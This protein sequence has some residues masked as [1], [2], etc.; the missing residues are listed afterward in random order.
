MSLIPRESYSF[1]EH[2]TTTVV[3]SR[4]PKAQAEPVPVESPRKNP[5]IVP[6]PDPKPQPTASPPN[7]ALRRANAPPPRIPETPPS[8]R[9]PLSPSLKPKG[10]W[11]QRAPAMDPAPFSEDGLEPV[12][13]TMPA[14][15]A[16]NVIPMRP[17]QP[18]AASNDPAPPQ[19]E[20][21]HYAIPAAPTKP[22]KPRTTV[23]PEAVR[24][25]PRPGAVSSPQTDFFQ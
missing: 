9:M 25:S 19:A 8:R 18:E 22:V 4:K 12:H 21:I 23:Q 5:S 10:R 24:P 2:F 16:G 7:P 13:Y 3:P 11:N 17:A 6:L 15:P 1:P 14:L 20:V